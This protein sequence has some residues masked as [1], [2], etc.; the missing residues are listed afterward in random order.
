MSENLKDGKSVFSGTGMPDMLDSA[1][2]AIQVQTGTPQSET[3]T[4]AQSVEPLQKD[5]DNVAHSQFSA[6]R[7]KG[8]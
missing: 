4:E 6:G 1:W 5:V 8:S 2:L 3:L 7:R